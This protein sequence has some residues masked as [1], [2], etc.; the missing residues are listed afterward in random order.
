MLLVELRIEKGEVAC[1]ENPLCE[2]VLTNAGE[3][4]VSIPHPQFQRRFPAFRILDR[5][6]GAETLHEPAPV[7]PI[8]ELFAF[9]EPHA[10]V[11]LSC[12]L[13]DRVP[14]LSPGDYEV[15]AVVPSDGPRRSESE[16][17]RLKVRAVNPR[18]LALDTLATA[19]PVGVWVNAAADPPEIVRSLFRALP[20]G[21]VSEI[22]ALAKATLRARPAISLPTKGKDRCHHWIAW[23][24]GRKVKFL[25]APESEPPSE[26]REI[27]LPGPR[28]EIAPPLFSEGAAIVWTGDEESGALATLR[29][30]PEGGEVATIEKLAGAAP[31]WMTNH[32][33]SNGARTLALARATPSEVA[34]EFVP[35]TNREIGKPARAAAWPGRF[36]AAGSTL[37]YDDAVHGALL[38]LHVESGK[39]RLEIVRWESDPRG[40][41]AEIDRSPV[42]WN[43][44][45]PLSEAG[46][47][48]NDDGTVAALLRTAEGAWLLHWAGTTRPAPA[49]P[50]TPA[51]IF[52]PGG[53]PVLILPES[54]TGYR[55]VLAT[56]KPL[57]GGR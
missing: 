19:C 30:G 51:A 20:G 46:V 5:A 25:F 39:L 45:M 47:F 21:G 7:G 23:V 31:L 43:E 17:V 15:S 36:L 52:T 56:G 11:R 50:F 38:L 40:K 44:R 12:G 42:E 41:F 8:P 37:G 35:W 26:P 53:E 4:R 13:L 32:V 49:C 34:L 16:F 29:L 24:E 48:V 55:M 54:G 33:R 22:R 1:R 2:V 6:S 28:V 3:G 14:A 10:S 18:N 57:P 27:A 9:L